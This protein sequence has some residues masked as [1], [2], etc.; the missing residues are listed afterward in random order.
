MLRDSIMLLSS[1]STP[2]TINDMTYYLAIYGAEQ[3][4]SR[5]HE[6]LKRD[7][8]GW[9]SAEPKPPPPPPQPQSHP[10]PAFSL[11]SNK[12]NR[13]TFTK[14]DLDAVLAR[15]NKSEAEIQHE[16]DSA[17]PEQKKY[18]EALEKRIA[19]DSEELEKRIT[20]DSIIF[21]ADSIKAEE[22]TAFN[23]MAGKLNAVVNLDF[24]RYIPQIILIIVLGMFIFRRKKAINEE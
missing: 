2:H 21:V 4:T 24:S 17:H 8:N 15:F 7:S 22:E 6:I 13:P 14:E 5:Y 20:A 16:V 10:P 12:S 23:N 1:K 3:V 11:E 18:Y 19:V 9:S